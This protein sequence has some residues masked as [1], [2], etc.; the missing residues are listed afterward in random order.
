VE[1]VVVNATIASVEGELTGALV[2]VIVGA[3]TIVQEAEADAVREP[4][5]LRTVTVCWPGLSCEYDRGLVQAVDAARSRLQ[6]T[7]P[8]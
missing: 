5:E 4:M 8:V 1:F 6:L 2:N 3:V 7:R